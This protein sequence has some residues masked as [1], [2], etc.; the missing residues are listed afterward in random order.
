MNIG[1]ITALIV[2]LLAVPFGFR[3]LVRSERLN[4]WWFSVSAA[5]LV[6]I[7]IGFLAL[8]SITPA[9]A[10]P[11]RIALVILALNL[12]VGA[13]LVYTLYPWM[14]TVARRRSKDN[15]KQ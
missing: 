6:G 12:L 2:C 5:G 4:R 3:I 9:R 7:F 11:L 13:P 8:L 10:A 14:I 1:R 15:P